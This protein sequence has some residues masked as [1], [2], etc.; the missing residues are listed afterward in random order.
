MEVDD[1]T[2]AVQPSSPGPEWI[3]KAPAMK[4]GLVEVTI[5]GVMDTGRHSRPRLVS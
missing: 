4:A 2:A 5:A 1:V 3:D